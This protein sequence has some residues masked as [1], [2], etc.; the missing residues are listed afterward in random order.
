[1]VLAFFC[2]NDIHALPQ[3]YRGNDSIER[4]TQNQVEAFRFKEIRI[5]GQPTTTL[6]RFHL[7]CSVLD[8]M[9][10]IAHP[11]TSEK[12]WHLPKRANRMSRQWSS[13]ISHTPK[14]S[15]TGDP[16]PDTISPPYHMQPQNLDPPPLPLATLQTPTRRPGHQLHLNPPRMPLIDIIFPKPITA[17]SNKHI[18]L[19][20][21]RHT[22]KRN[23]PSRRSNQAR[24]NPIS[25]SPV[26][27]ASFPFPSPVHSLSRP[28]P[29]ASSTQAAPTRGPR[30]KPKPG[31][32]DAAGA[33]ASRAS[34]I[35][36]REPQARQRACARAM[37]RARDRRG[38]SGHR[39]SSARRGALG[40][41]TR[42]DGRAGVPRATLRGTQPPCPGPAEITVARIPRTDGVPR[43]RF[44]GSSFDASTL[45]ASTLKRRACHL[46]SASRLIRSRQ[47]TPGRGPRPRTQNPEP[48]NPEPQSPRTPSSSQPAS[49][50]APSVQTPPASLLRSSRACADATIGP[51]ESIERALHSPSQ[52]VPARIAP[53]PSSRSAS[54]GSDPKPS[55]APRETA[56]RR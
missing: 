49:Q 51:A 4:C 15:L 32:F 22:L 52:L 27:F 36:D 23:R 12:L 25:P 50:P 13:A 45:R 37:T 33:R 3:T 48:R 40:Y 46:R 1:M 9:R 39:L 14:V 11:F 42:G 18:A 55:L 53:P 16:S 54:D 28:S 56:S 21:Q 19:R 41:V 47:K 8:G 5:S 31:G 2:P 7:T 38:D 35:P 24:T 26:V 6:M 43:A 10:S 17:R 29:R 30:T 20:P 34:L 44:A